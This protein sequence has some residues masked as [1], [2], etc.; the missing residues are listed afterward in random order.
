M[1][2][3][4]GTDW[5]KFRKSTHLA[6]ADL[7]V[8]ASEGKEL[9]F[10]IKEVKRETGVNVSGTKMDG[11][12]CYFDEDIKPL[13]LNST[14]LQILSTFASNN[15]HTNAESYFIENYAG[16]FIELY[17]DRNVK[18]MG[19]ITDGV[20]VMQVQPKKNKVKKQFTEDNFEAAKKANA[21]I[22]KIKKAYLLTPEMET[23]YIDY[24]TK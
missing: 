24:A 6:S 18:F 1:E 13:K 3:K 5:R 11:V 20:R 4:T 19:A 8:I 7:D 10:T 14:N 9:K 17:V 16:M 12:F 15:G 22:E 23:K 21:T 2:S